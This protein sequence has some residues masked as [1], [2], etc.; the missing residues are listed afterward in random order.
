MTAVLLT[1]AGLAV[2]D[3]V[4]TSYGSGPYAIRRVSQPSYADFFY[5]GFVVRTWP[6]VSISGAWGLINDIRRLADG[7]YFT[8]ANDE[9]VVIGREADTVVTQ[10]GLFDVAPDDVPI[11]PWPEDFMVNGTVHP[12]AWVCFDHHQYLSPVLDPKAK[13]A[14]PVC[15]RSAWSCP[16]FELLPRPEPP[17]R[18]GGMQT[19][20]YL[21]S[22]NIN[23]QQVRDANAASHHV[24]VTL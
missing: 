17:A 12:Q 9:V 13:P 10:I 15:K 19:N 16:V 4:R 24:E 3:V 1:V 14:C 18:P 22:I 7:R 23:S 21:L 11:R 20:S 5:S 2:G 8:D 6:V